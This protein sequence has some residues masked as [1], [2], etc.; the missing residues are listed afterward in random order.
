M[1][2]GVF[3]CVLICMFVSGI[4]DRTCRKQ[5]FKAY[6]TTA[7]KNWFQIGAVIISL[8]IVTIMK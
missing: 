1:Y 4:R 8:K 3:T 7:L 5:L 2:I 6:S